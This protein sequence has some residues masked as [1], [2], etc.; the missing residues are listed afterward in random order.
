MNRPVRPIA[1]VILTACAVYPGLTTL[2]QG[3]YPLWAG[4]YFNL[5]GQLGPWMMLAQKVGIPPVAV[6]GAKAV[7]GAAWIFGV[8][9]LWAGDGRA[10]PL[11]LF[12]AVLSLLNPFGPTAMAVLALACIGFFRERPGTL[13]A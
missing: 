7:V 13:P 9:G 6:L 1:L 2:Y 10:L 3:L 5:V 8:P 12:A 11:V 4:D